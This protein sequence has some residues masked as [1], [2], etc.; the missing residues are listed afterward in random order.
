MTGFATLAGVLRDADPGGRPI[1]L[2]LPAVTDAR[3][4][5]RLGIQTYGFTPMRLPP[6]FDLMSTIHAADERIP[7]GEVEW[8]TAAVWEAVSRWRAD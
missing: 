2:V 7:A 6:G 8:G 3:H 5:A 4:L 1:P